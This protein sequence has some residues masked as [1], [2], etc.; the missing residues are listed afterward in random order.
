MKSLIDKGYSPKNAAADGD[1]VSFTNDKAAFMINGPWNTTPLNAIKKLK[2]GAAPV[3]N[4]GGTQAT[5]AG[6]HQF[7]LPRQHE[8]GRE[9][10]DRQPGVRQLDLPAVADLGRRRH[11]AGAQ[12]ASGRTRSSRPKGAVTEF[13]KELD[14][15]HFV[16]PIPGVNDVMPEYGQPPSARRMLGKK[17][18]ATALSR[19]RGAGPTRS[20]PRTR[21]STA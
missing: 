7:V 6:S 1:F 5:W 13:A 9:Q 4:I 21:R 17:D 18:I 2:W 14:Y 10:G 16:P 15:I 11:G 20:W 19:G 3:P 8:P 12:L